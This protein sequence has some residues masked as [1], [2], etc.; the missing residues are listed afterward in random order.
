MEK[1]QK[2]PLIRIEQANSKR[3]L[4]AMRDTTHNTSS[5]S[6]RLFGTIHP[7]SLMKAAIT[8][9]D[10]SHLDTGKGRKFSIDEFERTCKCWERWYKSTSCGLGNMGAFAL[11]VCIDFWSYSPT[12]HFETLM[13]KKKEKNLKPTPISPSLSIS[14]HR[15]SISIAKIWTLNNQHFMHSTWS[16]NTS[17]IAL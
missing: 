15:S 8:L 1:R 2:L 13:A 16:S 11:P 7:R 6:L 14:R 4:E 5:H 9:I 3:L 12:P 10:A 17:G